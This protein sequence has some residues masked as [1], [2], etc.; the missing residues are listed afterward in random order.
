MLSETEKRS[1]VTE[2]HGRKHAET[3][4]DNGGTEQFA[5]LGDVIHI[6][7]K[8]N[9]EELKNEVQLGVRVHDVKQPGHMKIPKSDT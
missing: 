2:G 4:F 7:L 5:L 1:D 3:H 6:A 8:I 9:V